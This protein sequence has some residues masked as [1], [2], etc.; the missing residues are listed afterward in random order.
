MASCPATWGDL[1]TAGLRQ[2]GVIDRVVLEHHQGVEQLAQPGQA[3]ISAS[4]RCWCAISRDWLSCSSGSSSR[5]GCAGVELDTQRQRVDEQPHHALDAGNLRRTARHRHAEHHVVAPRQPPEQQRPGRLDE[6][7][8]RQA[9]PPAPAASAP[10]S[11][12][13][14]ATAECCSGSPAPAPDRAA[15]A[16]CGSSSPASASRHAA[17]AAAR[18]CAGEPRQIV[19]VR[20]H[21]RQR[22]RRPR[23]A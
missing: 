21:P 11:A 15:P 19:P 18:S 9:L 8:Q 16:A 4:P 22:R 2:G 14:S 10:P 13:R 7:V 5:N 20:R 12:A 23:C 6:G 1:Q 3:W 17:I